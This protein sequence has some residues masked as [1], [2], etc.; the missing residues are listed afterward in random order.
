[1]T[2][3]WWFLVISSHLTRASW[4]TNACLSERTPRVI[5][6][7]ECVCEHPGI[8]TDPRGNFNNSYLILININITYLKTLILLYLIQ[9]NVLKIYYSFTSFSW[10]QNVSCV[11]AKSV[12]IINIFTLGSLNVGAFEKITDKMLNMVWISTESFRNESGKVWKI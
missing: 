7:C 1:M 4:G 11:C 3:T 8:L 12:F 10:A 9:R 5:V 6:T 2:N